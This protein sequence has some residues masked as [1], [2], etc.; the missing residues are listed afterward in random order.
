MEEEK[1]IKVGDE[2]LMDIGEMRPTKMS[3]TDVYEHEYPFLWWSV[4]KTIVCAMYDGIY[5]TTRIKYDLDTFKKCVIKS[6]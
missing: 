5:K 6:L 4:K 3:V 1:E 2:F